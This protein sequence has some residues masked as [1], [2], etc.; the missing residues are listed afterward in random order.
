[1]A[2][3]LSQRGHEVHVVTYHLGDRS[4][5]L[6]FA[7]HRIRDVPSYTDCSPGPTL[8]KLLHLDPLLVGRVGRL[9]DS[10]PFDVVHAHHYEGLL[11][12]LL[13]GARRRRP[14]VVYDAHTLLASELPY[15]GMGLSRG[16]KSF[17]GSW[18]DRSLPPRA[19]HIIAVTDSIRDSLL[20]TTCIG[21]D[22]VTLVTNGVESEHFS[23]VQPLSGR[24]PAR[25]R[26]VFA[27]NLAA[28]QG[29]DLLL[30]AFELIRRRCADARLSFLTDSDFAPYVALAESLGIRGSIDVFNPDYAALPAYL[31]SA[32]VL[33][34]PRPE[35]DGIPQKLLNYMAAGRPIVSF[36]GSA[37]IIEHETT[38]LLVENG[39]VNAF[40]A[41]TLRLLLHPQLGDRLG[42]NAQR[43][44]N[45]D[46]G[47][48]RAAAKTEEV[49]ASLLNR[50]QG[51]SA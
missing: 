11:V 13:S 29:V 30:R 26:I 47:W 51:A 28:Y 50:R 3:A 14:P 25:R 37:R 39:D 1:M 2:E 27:G 36:A 5:P 19:D 22:R 38:G 21:G 35:C 23:A 43:L 32:D 48:Q 4:I 49:Y 17:L 24:H 46:F 10:M 41:A 8:R 9:L 6:P 45:S 44:A 40:A 18:L 33:L 20:A 12:A 15:Y 7:V 16:M 31:Q 34:N 42:A